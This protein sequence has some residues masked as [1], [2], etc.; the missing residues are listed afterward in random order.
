MKDRPRIKLD[1]AIKTLNESGKFRNL[2][3]KIESG[4][5]LIPL[6]GLG[7]SSKFFLVYALR[8]T[9]RRPILVLSPTAKRADTASHDL[10][11]FLGERPRV[12]LRK[13][14][15]TG[16][17]V[18]STAAAKSG[19][20]RIAWLNSA[21]NG[22]VLVAESQALFDK[23]IPRDVFSK[24]VIKVGKG[25]LSFR[26]ELIS[27][28]VKSG[29]TLTD[30]VQNEGDISR[31]GS[32]VDV[33]SPGSGHPVRLEYIGDEIGSIRRF[34]LESQKSTDR[35]ESA[36]LLPASE[37]IME[38]EPL[39]RAV[40]YLKKRAGESGVTAREKLPLIEDIESGIRVQN[41]E[42]LLPAFYPEP[43][44][45]LDFLPED[46]LI[47]TEDAEDSPKSVERWRESLGLTKNYLTKNIKI[48]PGMDELYFTEEEVGESSGRFR[49]IMIHDLEYA[50]GRMD[51]IRFGGEPASIEVRKESES[52]L[53]AIDE[54]IYE[55]RQEGFTLLFVFRTHTELEKLLM[56]LRERG[57]TKINAHTGEL[58]H[59]F[60]LS[61]GKFEIV[62]EG[63]IFGEKR[64]RVSRGRGAD[65]PG[66]FITSF[67]ELK[68]G[69]YIVHVDFGIGIFRSL[70]RLRIGD[71]EGDFIQCEYA[72][73]DKVYVPIDRLK[74]VQ[75][76][77]GEGKSTK[78]DRLGQESWKKRVRR[79]RAAVENVARE[80][81]ELYARRKALKGYGYLPRGEM[82]REFELG[83]SYEETPDQEAAIEEVMN[84]MEAPRPMDRLICGDV[85]FGKTEVALR[86]AFR[87]VTDGKQ[88][89]FLVPTTL[90]A[91]QHYKTA[92]SRLRGYPVVVDALSR[93]RTGKEES[94]IRSRLEDGKIDII[95]G[96]H[97]L[98]GEKIR[99]KD[100]GLVI[101]D[102]EHRFGVS[103]KE[104]LRKIKEG[105]DTISL[106][107]TPI[108]RTLQ[109]SLAKIRDISLI[110][111]P[112]EGR[113]T[114]E[115][116]IHHSSPAVIEEAITRE[117]DR[118][119]C[120][121]FIH[122]RIEDIY[123]V[124]DRVRKLF[125]EA[126]IEV[127]HGRMRERDLERSI[128]KFIEG[129]V[130]ILV[131]TAIVESGLDIPRANTIIID[132]AHTFGLAD[133]YQ[134]RGRVGRSDK[135]AY[136]YFLVP[137]TES[138]TLD[139]RRRLKAI[140][141]FREL[142]SGFK[143][144]LSDL[145][146][147]GA[148]QLFGVEQSGH[149]ADVGLELYLD[150]LEGAVRRLEGKVPLEEPEPD[151]SASTPAF[152]PDEYISNDTERLLVYKR[153]SY[154][155]TEEGLREITGE[156]RD[157][158]GEIPPPAHS[159]ID[160]IGLKIMMKKLGIEKA[161]I[162]SK[163]AAFSFSPKSGL[164]ERFKPQGRMEVYFEKRDP[165]G[166]T[167]KILENLAA[168]GARETG[169]K[170]MTRRR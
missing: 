1:N 23:T 135:K 147:R 10:S 103:Q 97:K 80:L 54:R 89:A 60:K 94:G 16:R 29:Y 86:A 106:S 141:E 161:D 47:I 3:R 99:F 81:L 157:R 5:K 13:E 64:E 44:S 24:S 109:L 140:S 92:V 8:E 62:T 123:R 96:T 73:G 56:L 121:F 116:Y 26:D 102:E 150:M 113:Q 130:D 30:F 145:E 95:I 131:T 85:G 100:L 22:E 87:A 40:E 77:I 124:A 164:Y 9:T 152:I 55:A 120:V 51:G 128:S 132:D 148:G 65:V 70:K 110:N 98:L 129:G 151:I 155:T 139:A 35:V 160:I 52:P 169:Q 156:L 170:D 108:P 114:I 126:K 117:L 138:L 61:E 119:G 38:P 83:F 67:S 32:I 74:L 28:L 84:D 133:L 7:G 39:G 168:P 115:T 33:F 34:N 91:E 18:F 20:D 53:D 125:P 165:L 112:P 50:E 154:I 57:I 46:A 104:K 153:L 17:P 11:F 144:A 158:F 72:G 66:A 2:L 136:A 25:L 79:V 19:S 15:G 27:G 71:S 127:T 143:L 122:N 90:L 78:V 21:I 101:I 149:I 43:G 49:N 58:S 12:L 162:G 134:L 88:V 68:P 37:I 75:R 59:G 31:R 159:L 48:A 4:E 41:I 146:I 69:D 142:G 118:G 166:E 111:T 163:M 107:A 42:W 45:A 93:F 63:D 167:K 137:G 82:F 14:I 105:V 6:S 76:Y 36:E